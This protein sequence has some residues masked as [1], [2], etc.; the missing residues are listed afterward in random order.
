VAEEVFT[1]ART[2][3]TFGTEELEVARYKGSL[4]RIVAI[5]TRYC[6]AYAMYLTSSS[7]LFNATKVVTLACGGVAALKGVITPE[8]LTAFIL[9]VEFVTT[10][11]IAVC[12]QYAS[13]MEV[14]APFYVTHLF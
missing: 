8:Q 3:R 9:Y 6:L 4:Q 5:A 10:A 7:F 14:V 12:E 1:L 11:S 2:V 13:V